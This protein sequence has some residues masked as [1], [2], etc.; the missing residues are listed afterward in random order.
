[1]FIG[2]FKA[3]QLEVARNGVTFNINNGEGSSTSAISN[4]SINP[5]EDSF[6]MN[7]QVVDPFITT[8]TP[9]MDIS[10]DISA[11]EENSSNE[12]MEIAEYVEVVVSNNICEHMTKLK[13]IKPAVWLNK[14]NQCL[15]ELYKEKDS[16]KYFKCKQ[17][18]CQGTC[19]I[20][21]GE[22]W[23]TREHTNHLITNQE[24]LCLMKVNMA[25]FYKA[26]QDLISTPANIYMSIVNKYSEFQAPRGHRKKQISKIRKLRCEVRN[27]K[28]KSITLNEF[29]DR[30]IELNDIC[31]IIP[32]CSVCLQK[33]AN[34]IFPEYQH[35]YACEDCAKQFHKMPP[36]EQMSVFHMC[37]MCRT[38]V[39]GS[40]KKSFF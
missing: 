25:I 38:P 23:N 3:H 36:N 14:T 5:S 18:G 26:I 12:T 4:S 11:I 1:M 24:L 16:K 29:N 33:S 15:Y 17:K 34:F 7:L 10:T 2:P 35:L 40:Q 32:K 8:N 39:V 37:P 19:R 13:Y 22:L 28:R 21:N 31:K 30:F 20:I 27:N 6:N 9:S